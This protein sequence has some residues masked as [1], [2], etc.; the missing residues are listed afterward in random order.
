V[1][2]EANPFLGVRGVRLT[3]ADRDLFAAQLR[4]LARTAAAYPEISVMVPMV[5]GLEELDEVR[6]L[7]AEC[8]GET[9]FRF[10]TMIEVP[11]AAVLAAEV[12]A[13]VDFLSVGTNDLTAYV[14]A[15]DRGNTR[16]DY[17][18]DEFHPAVL[19]TLRLIR[20][21]AGATPVSICGE[22]AGDPRALALLVGLGY[23]R[24]SVSGPLVPVVKERV[25]ELEAAGTADGVAAVLAA[26]RRTDVTAALDL[27]APRG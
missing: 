24:L 18:Y 17:L 2:A 5:S 26:R 23:H 19:R 8:A 10:G 12:A 13:E 6:A 3:L 14:L 21:G 9:A 4:A 22:L 15:A 25:R 1:E 7:L 16:L 27:L 11:S 20:V